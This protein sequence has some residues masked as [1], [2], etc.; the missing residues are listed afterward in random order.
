M[1]CLAG[2]KEKNRKNYCAIIPTPI[3][4]EGSVLMCVFV[5]II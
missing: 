5:N 1:F 3:Y 4:A 2:K